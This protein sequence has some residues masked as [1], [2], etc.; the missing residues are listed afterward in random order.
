MRKVF[1]SLSLTVGA[2]PVGC[3]PP[4][5]MAAAAVCSIAEMESTCARG[6]RFK[7]L[8]QNFCL[9]LNALAVQTLV[10]AGH[11]IDREFVLGMVP[12]GLGHP[13]ARVRITQ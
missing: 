12:G 3:G 10:G 9:T 11:D 1:G 5:T 6:F 7:G 13:L 4:L 8:K 2:G